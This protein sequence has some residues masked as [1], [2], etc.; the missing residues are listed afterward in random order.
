VVLLSE[1]H[2]KALERF[3][4]PNYHF[5]QTDRFPGR[6]GRAAI[7][8]KRAIPHNHVDLPLLLST[9]ATGVCILIGNSEM[10]FAAAVLKPP[11]HARPGLE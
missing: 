2:L 8:A 4:T 10:L 5:Y 3:F 1:I 6:K 9:E 7:A 11:G